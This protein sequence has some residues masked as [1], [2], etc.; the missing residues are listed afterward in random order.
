MTAPVRAISYERVSGDEQAREGTSLDTQQETNAAYI[1]A[2]GWTQVGQIVDDGFTA[3]NNSRPGYIDLLQQCEAGLVDVIVVSKLDR[4]SRS[5]RHFCETEEVLDSLGV[6]FASVSEGL[7][8]STPVGRLLRRIIVTFAEFERERIVERMM[9]GHREVV[10]QGFWR[11]GP[12]PFGYRLVREENASRTSIVMNDEEADV[13]KRAADLIVNHGYNTYSATVLLN[14]QGITTRSGGQWRHNNLRWHLR[15]RHLTGNWSYSHQGE[16]V[17][18]RIPAIFDE[19]EW[20]AIQL[21]INGGPRPQRKSRVYALTGRGRCHLRCD[22]GGNF[23]GKHDRSKPMSWYVCGRNVQEFGAE[24]CHH[25]PRSLRADELDEAVIDA[26]RPVFSED[27]LLALARAHL[28]KPEDGDDDVA[29]RSD[30]TRTLNGLH[31][32]KKAI[33][34][35]SAQAGELDYLQEAI[36]DIENEESALRNQ[37]RVLDRRTRSGVERGTVED[38]LVDLAQ[39]ASR[40]SD[41]LTMEEKVE[42]FDL[43]KLDLVRVGAE[44]LEGTASIP[45]PADGGEIWVE[46]PQPLLPPLGSASCRDLPPIRLRLWEDSPERRERSGRAAASGGRV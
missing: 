44:K 27:Y 23:G 37:L 5:I 43:L 13:L 28:M 2:R 12:A 9:E 15:Q 24:R 38:Q 35:K 40:K 46:G 17:A 8:S 25:R 6:E 18:M 29:L 20:G 32:E 42:L 10:R 31:N 30:L 22:C 26:L 7:D 41:T 34:R 14:A 1:V 19:A 33:V 4:F 16:R 36:S 39:R 3:K 11:G 21:A 45:V